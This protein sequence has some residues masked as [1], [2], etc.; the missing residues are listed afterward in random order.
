MENVFQKLGIT[1]PHNL[2]QVRSSIDTDAQQET[3]LISMLKEHHGY[4]EESIQ[5]IMDPKASIPDKRAHLNRFFNLVEMHGK[6]EQETLYVHLQ[7][8]TEEEA[9]LEGLSGQD[10]HEIAFQLRDELVAMNYKT[11]WNDE[12]AAKA[13]VAATLVKNHIKE[14]ESIMFPIA[15][16]DLSDEELEQMRLDYIAKCRLYLLH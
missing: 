14:E 11:Q 2:Q 6:A 8:N 9:R 15:K 1:E 3:G 4:L 5:V 10:E 16:K 12:I 7:Q 13:K